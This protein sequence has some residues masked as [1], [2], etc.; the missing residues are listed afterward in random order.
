MVVSAVMIIYYS[1]ISTSTSSHSRAQLL[2]VTFSPVYTYLKNTTNH[3]NQRCVVNRNVFKCRQWKNLLELGI[4]RR[5][6]LEIYQ[7]E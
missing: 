7:S 3:S 1:F 5:I 2:L 6:F 4:S